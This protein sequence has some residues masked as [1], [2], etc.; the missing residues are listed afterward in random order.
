MKDKI[1]DKLFEI[2]EQSLQ[3]FTA[4][5]IPN[6]DPKTVLGIRT[7]KLKQLAKELFIKGDYQDFLYSLPHDYLEENHLHAFLISQIKDFDECIKKTN[8]FLPFV[9]NW[10]TCDS[11]KPMIFKKN[12]NEL[13]VEIKKWLKSEQVYTIR[14]GVNMLMTHFLD[15]DF[16]VE[17]ARLVA[18]VKQDD[19]YLKM[20]VAWYFATALAKQWGSVIS[21]VEQRVLPA[22][23]H[24]KTIQKAVESFRITK[25]QKE[26]LKTL[27]IKEKKQ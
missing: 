24:N 3:K 6:I 7:P 2:K 1:L 5:L 14:F 4:K 22:W 21:I 10:A 25:E 9:D 20:V 19:Y 18:N 15:E 12:K 13:L 27:K 16:K 17:Y 8:E 11:F 23:T 26:Y